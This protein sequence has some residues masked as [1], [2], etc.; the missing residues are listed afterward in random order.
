MAKSS[1]EQIE[2]DDRKVL[3][4]LR[5]NS[6]QSINVI[7]DKV[8][9]SRQKVWRIIKKLQKNKTIWSYTAVV[10]GE[11][12]G[13]KSFILLGKR[14]SKPLAKEMVDLAV[15]KKLERLA[16]KNNCFLDDTAYL[17]GEFDFINVFKA[18]NLR[19]A[20][21][22]QDEFNRLFQGYLERTIII[23]IL[24]PIRV[25]GIF[26]PEINKLYEFF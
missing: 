2:K 22:Y 5:K 19:D 20:K 11:S 7:S 1:K 14:T 16:L 15:L 6:S 10:N 3:E 26:N 13:L 23:E 17:N 18:K 9:F 12:L 8:G 4:E 25:S 24:F 21:K